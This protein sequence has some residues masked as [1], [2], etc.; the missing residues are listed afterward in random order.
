MTRVCARIVNAFIILRVRSI[1]CIIFYFI[2]R[3]LWIFGRI[4]IC[5]V[6]RT[7]T[8]IDIIGNVIIVCECV[9]NYK[10]SVR[11]YNSRPRVITLSLNRS[12]R[13]HFFSIRVQDGTIPIDIYIRCL[14]VLEWRILSIIFCTINVLLYNTTSTSLLESSLLNYLYNILYKLC[15]LIC[16]N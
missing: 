3:Y 10:F 7:R 5:F 15:S 11:R 6:Y 8:Y 4:N 1:F 2:G 12:D 13:I 14:G 9:H 16:W